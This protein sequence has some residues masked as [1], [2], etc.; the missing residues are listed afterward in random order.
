MSWLTDTSNADVLQQIETAVSSERNRVATTTG[1][2]STRYGVRSTDAY[3]EHEEKFVEEAP[4]D[5][6]SVPAAPPEPLG[7]GAPRDRKAPMRF[8]F[9]ISEAPARIP[10][11]TI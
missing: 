5:L 2:R 6:A 1:T 8:A 9:A 11:Y 7:R 10:T 4:A 3:A